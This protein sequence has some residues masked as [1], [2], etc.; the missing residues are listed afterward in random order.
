[1]RAALLAQ[2][3]GVSADSKLGMAGVLPP[4]EMDSTESVLAHF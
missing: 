4:L 2:L 1:M 3:D